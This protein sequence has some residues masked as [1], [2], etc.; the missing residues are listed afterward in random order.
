MKTKLF[1]LLLAVA[2][3]IGT[4]FASD[5]QVNGI[6]YN[7][8]STNKTAEVTY[9]GSS[10]YTYSNEYAG[11]VTIP[12]SV[13]Y[14]GTTYSVTR[15]GDSAFRDCSGLTSVTIPNSV[16]SIGG[17]AF[18]GCTGLTKVNI[19]DIAAWCNIAFGSST[20]NPLN[21]AEHLFVNDVEVT[22]LVIPNSVTS[23]GDY[24]FYY[25]SGLTSVTIPSSVTS[26]G[27]RA[28]LRCRGLTSVT[29]PSS[30]TSIGDY[31]F[32]DCCGLTSVTIPNNVTSIGGIAFCRVNNIIYSG[33]ATDSPWGAKCVNGYVDGYLVYSDDTKTTLL[34]CSA[35]ATGEIVIPNSVTSI[36][37]YAFYY[38]RS[39]TSVTIPSSVTS[40]G[41]NAFFGCNGLISVTCE[42]TAPPTLGGTS[43]FSN[44]DK[45]IPVYVPGESVDLYKAADR[46]KEFTNILPTEET[47]APCILASGTC[48][49]Q[50]DNLIWEL[51]CDSLLTISGT[52]AMADY[53]SG[54]APWY[55]YRTTITSI[56]RWRN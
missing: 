43:V 45:S 13:T 34:G 28:F 29:I 25:C 15:I 50:G 26:I 19:T 40:I 36:G 3:S 6:W 23:I 54:S 17:Y 1:S 2:V 55:T 9:H 31:A 53:S 14:S 21:F 41:N 22:E 33:E 46:W 5:T 32:Y 47:P 42:A 56:T 52:G 44:V 20:A 49:A 8:N 12:A 30:V 16:T 35:A 11:V 18:D 37:Q 38:C 7:F 51:S 39:L 24:A 27:N 4:M 48:G 10:Y